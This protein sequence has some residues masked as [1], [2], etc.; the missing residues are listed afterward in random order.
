MIN[1]F[2]QELLNFYDCNKDF[3]GVVHSNVI[4]S[5]ND[6]NCA[7]YPVKF[8]FDTDILL[9]ECRSVDHLFF[10]HRSLDKKSGYGHRGWQSLTLH[11]LDKHKTEH[12]TKYGFSSLEEA[13]YHWTD[14]CEL[15]PNLYRCLSNLPFKL[16]DRV[17]IMKLAPKGY[18]MPHTDAKTRMFGPLNIAINNP[19]DCY[20]V[21]KNV[22]IVPYTSG[23]GMILDVG[24]EHAVINFSDEPRYH[25]IVHGHYNK[26]FYN[27]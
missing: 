11:G 22:G 8:N 15:V 3:S 24:T 25:V 5:Q 18:I 9:E 1:E 17:R 14:V 27:L 2:P 19:D 16:F 6:A 21:I 20:F 26:E 23:N 4:D 13:N 12:Y 10:N 7:Y